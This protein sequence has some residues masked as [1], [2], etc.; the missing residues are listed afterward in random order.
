M[1]T[2]IKGDHI[3]RRISDNILQLGNRHFNYFV[4]GRQEAAIIECGVTGGVLSFE[5][6]WAQLPYQPDIKY[7]LAMHAHF[8][9][10]CGVPALKTLFPQA[11]VLGSMETQK[12]INK[13]KIMDNFF[14][15]DKKMS[16]VLIAEGILEAEPEERSAQSI[17]LDHIIG[18]GDYL[19]LGNSMELK[20]LNVPGH[21]PC[22]IACYLPE[23][24]IM[25]L[26]D[27]AGF[28]ISD[29]EIFPI[30]FQSYEI[31]I[32]TIKRLMSFPTRILGIA[33]ERV[34]TDGDVKGFYERA[35]ESA[36]LAFD[37]IAL[38]LNNGWEEDR[39][40]QSLF[41]HYYHG[42]LR[43]YTPENIATCV[44]LLLRRVKECL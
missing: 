24:Q 41:S 21:S 19:N 28:Q 27:S 12:I 20:V 8:D 13:P 5:K 42:N 17:I 34:W 7:L 2:L 39:I 3:L 15:Q 18:E 11:A 26:S 43:I 30:F 16:Q 4:V 38:M 32:E 31:Y 23:E 29:I 14:D 40:K 25:F 44:A 10:I 33:H 22:G 37:N 35:L 36:R 9:H 6:Q 1:L